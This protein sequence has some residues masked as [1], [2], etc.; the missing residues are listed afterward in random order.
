MTTPTGFGSWNIR[1]SVIVQ[2][3]FD[4]HLD[5]EIVTKDEDTTTFNYFYSTRKRGD[6]EGAMWEVGYALPKDTPFQAWKIDWG[7]SDY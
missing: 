4:E 1:L 3:P 7:N 6:D 2:K 5:W